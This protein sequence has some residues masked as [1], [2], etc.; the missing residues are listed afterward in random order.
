MN[1]ADMSWTEVKEAVSK[2][3]KLRVIIPIGSFEQHGPHLPLRTDSIIAEHVA[4]KVL[5]HR[6]SVLFPTLTLGYSLEHTEFPGT[7]SLTQQT[8]FS[9]ISEIADCLSKSGFRTLILINGHGGNRP[10]LDSSITSIKHTHPEL[11]LYSFTILDIARKKFAELRKS[12]RGMIGHADELETSMMLAIQPDIVKISKAIA[13]TPTFPPRFSLESEDLQN[14]TYGWKT[15]EISK[16]GIIG[17]P[18]YATAETGRLV[19][20]HVVQ[21]ITLVIGD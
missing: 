10:I 6:R 21:T 16:S 20:D 13:E 3:P 18:T 12:P 15:K 11:K 14:V 4:S 8:F 2:D 1:L 5:N 19:L 9:I 7:V 17:D